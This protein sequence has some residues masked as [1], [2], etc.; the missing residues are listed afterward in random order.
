M[1]GKQAGRRGGRWCSRYRG[2]FEWS[3]LSESQLSAP[4]LLAHTAPHRTAPPS[5]QFHVPGAACRC[6]MYCPSSITVLLFPPDH[7]RR[8]DEWYDPTV[9]VD[10]LAAP[11]SDIRFRGHLRG[12]AAT[13]LALA[14]LSPPPTPFSASGGGGAATTT[15][16]RGGSGS[17]GFRL[18]AHPTGFV[19]HRAHA[20][21]RAKR[22]YAEEEA[23]EAERRDGAA[24]R[25]SQ[26][27]VSWGPAP[28]GFV[29]DAPVWPRVM[30]GPF[31][32]LICSLSAHRYTVHLSTKV[33]CACREYLRASHSLLCA[34]STAGSGPAARGRRD[35]GCM[36]ADADVAQ[37]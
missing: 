21:G 9:M 20:P 34:G 15:E 13:T 5:L 8:Y 33:Y 4:L 7:C 3:G 12:R 6:R 25:R 2:S 17:S 27:Q 1:I 19:V 10:R 37:P 32:L 31:S 28:G 18:L 23:A 35:P 16:S 14:T 30:G 36:G 26:L 11:W 24:A 29:L 22:Q